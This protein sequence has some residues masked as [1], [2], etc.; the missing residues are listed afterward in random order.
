MI[1]IL[2]ACLLSSALYADGLL[3][4][5]PEYHATRFPWPE[6]SGPRPVREKTTPTKAAAHVK[7]F[8]DSRGY[9]EQIV[10][11]TEQY[12]QT[13]P[14]YI[15]RQVGATFHALTRTELLSAVSRMPILTIPIG[16]SITGL[17]IDE[18]GSLIAITTSDDRLVLLKVNNNSIDPE[19]IPQELSGKFSHAAVLDFNPAGTL[20]AVS[21]FD[22]TVRVWPISDHMINPQEA[23]FELPYHGN[24]IRAL[25]FNKQG[26]WLA[27]GYLDGGISLWPVKNS[28]INTE[29]EPTLITT[30]YKLTCLSFSQNG[31]LLV[32]GTEQ[33]TAYVWR[34]SRTAGID[35]RQEPI[36][37]T[38]QQ[39]G[40]INSIVFNPQNTLCAIGY[41]YGRVELWK[42]TSRGISPDQTPT[43]LKLEPSFSIKSIAFNHRSTLCAIGARDMIVL[44]TIRPDGTI[45]PDQTPV[46]FK[47]HQSQI[48]SVAFTRDDSTL[49]SASL[50]GTIKLWM[51]PTSTLA[52]DQMLCILALGKITRLLADPSGQGIED[53]VDYARVIIHQIRESPILARFDPPIRDGILKELS[54]IEKTYGLAT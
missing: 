28:W 54:Q 49:I 47:E 14:R 9:F 40:A 41:E 16:R 48:T 6:R 12:L 5:N 43:V 4:N 35:P 42:V 29:Q 26:T 20:L 45:D 24:V 27:A 2:I 50:D 33:E 34:V 22:K 11:A 15:R 25:D 23:P 44:Y 3:F 30:P 32:A 10:K 53:K 38:G 17:T 31:A 51:I 21:S 8:L 18:A 39:Q 7:K 13:L 19:E 36:P 52:V 37:L 46:Y 1:Y